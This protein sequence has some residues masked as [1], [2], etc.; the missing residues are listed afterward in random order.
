MPQQINLINP[1][2]RKTRDLFSAMPL[3][4]V[5]GALLV[6]LLTAGTMARQHVGSLQTEANKRAQELQAAQAQL[7]EISSTETGAA[8]DTVLAEELAKSRAMLNLREEVIATL[9][10]GIFSDNAGFAEFMRGFARQAPQ[11][12][13]LTGFA[14]NPL[15]RNVEIRGRML[16]STALP[17]FIQRLREE[18][19][20]QGLSFSSLTIERP[21]SA[22]Q[23]GA[24]AGTDNFLSPQAMMNA[25]AKQAEFIEFVIRT[26][27]DKPDTPAAARPAEKGRT[28]VLELRR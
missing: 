25:P 14:L 28:T 21:S 20:F 26:T 12:L 6:L 24:A 11:G 15:E 5:A 4:L 19:A 9:E 16:K 3:A 18:T 1:A 10:R 27:P 7:L 22:E 17:E 2:L 13:W 8:T 23:T